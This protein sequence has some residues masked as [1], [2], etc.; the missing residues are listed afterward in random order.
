MGFA[1]VWIISWGFVFGILDD[2]SIGEII[3]FII[4]GILPT[5][6]KRI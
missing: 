3:G 5:V 2:P 1:M 4:I 6:I